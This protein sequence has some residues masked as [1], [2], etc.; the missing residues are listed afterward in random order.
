VTARA[1]RRFF[2]RPDDTNIGQGLARQAVPCGPLGP[3][4]VI[5]ANKAGRMR[6]QVGQSLDCI[7]LCMRSGLRGEARAQA[8]KAY[9]AA[10]HIPKT[11]LTAGLGQYRIKPV[12]GQQRSW[13]CLS[14]RCRPSVHYRRCRSI[15]VRLK[16]VRDGHHGLAFITRGQ[17]TCGLECFDPSAIKARMVAHPIFRICASPGRPCSAMRLNVCPP[18]SFTPRS[19]NMRVHSRCGRVSCIL[20]MTHALRF[21]GRRRSPRLGPSGLTVAYVSKPDRLNNTVSCVTIPDLTPAQLCLSLAHILRRPIK[22]DLF[23]G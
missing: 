16:A 9:S 3:A 15:S 4:G 10:F 11:H 1:R 6:R 2:R 13:G 12:F 18:D 5:G 14:L 20:S 7:F 21:G 22:I 19:P 23:A 8:K 17:C